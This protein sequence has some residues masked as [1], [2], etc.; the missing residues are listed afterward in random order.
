[1]RTHTPKTLVLCEGKADKLVMECLAK[2]SGLDQNLKF[3]SYDGSS[4][5]REYLANLK[6]SPEFTRG[7]YAKILV[8][9][10]A[11]E[12]YEAAVQSLQ[13]AILEVFSVSVEIPGQWGD[14]ISGGKITSHVI[15]GSHQT[16]MIETLCLNAARAKNPEQFTCLDSFIDCLGSQW[17]QRPH[18][19]VRF[20]LWTIIAQ[21]Q[22]AKDRLSIERAIAKIDFNWDDASYDSLKQLFRD[23]S[24]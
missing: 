14:L 7:E 11:D 24:Q 21:G 9:R 16:G 18:E 4:K 12:N 5:L 19:K 6:V 13:N 17:G 23:I 15:P 20:T 1:M 3:E 2:H 8:T 22:I 10:D